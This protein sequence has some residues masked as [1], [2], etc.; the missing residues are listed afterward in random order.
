MRKLISLLFLWLTC[1]HAVC[2]WAQEQPG[3]EHPSAPQVPYV[4]TPHAVVEEMLRL[5][6]VTPDDVLYDL[7]CGDGRIV[8]AAA[9]R[10]GARGVGVDINPQRISE[11]QANAQ[12]AGVADRVQFL[13]QDLFATDLHAATVVT[14]YLLPTINLQLRSIL[15]EQLRPGSRVVSHE[16]HMDDWRPDRTAEV[17]DHKI[18]LWVIPAHIAGDWVSTQPCP[19]DLQPCTLRL[20]QQFQQVGGVLRI[21]GREIPLMNVVL[22]GDLFRFVV[23]PRERLWLTFSARVD[24][25]TMT[26]HVK[27]Q[28][29][30]TTYWQPWVAQRQRSS[31]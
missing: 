15:L 31:V 29:A 30:T 4:P 5:A 18:Y 2:V 24:G 3:R 19:P 14:L 27:I 22:S 10:F 9:Q 12:Q 1:V 16:F 7:G 17:D 28:E 25:D 23:L 20:A 6:N 11:A 8:I 21:A 26:G 13:Q